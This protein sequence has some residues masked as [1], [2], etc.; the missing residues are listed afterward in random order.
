MKYKILLVDDEPDILEIISYNL[1]KEG[2]T[3]ETALNGKIALDKI[4]QFQ[5]DL[6]LLDIMMPI[7]D[8]LQTCQE[9]RKNRSMD[10]VSILFLTAKGDEDTHIKALDY[11]GDDFVTKPV[12]V[13]VLLSRIRA[14]IRRKI[15]PLGNEGNNEILSFEELQ[16]NPLKM[17]VVF[18]NTK[19]EFARK[20]FLLLYLLASEPGKVF[21]RDEILDKIWGKDIIVGDRT[22]DVHI[23]KLREK[24][25]DSY[26]KTIKGVGYKFE[27]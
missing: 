7:M 12:A 13:K 26:I 27:A 1:G 18:K 16:I 24:L 25:N 23:R 8:G 22:I 21:R 11:G 2:F 6:I 5:P 14:V 15:K 20:E 9:I 17:E 3:V 4:P 10:N 19:P